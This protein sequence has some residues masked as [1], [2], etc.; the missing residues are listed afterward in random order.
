MNNI[1]LNRCDVVKY[2]K[3]TLYSSK[4]DFDEVKNAR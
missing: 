2:V 3:D 1:K 4:T